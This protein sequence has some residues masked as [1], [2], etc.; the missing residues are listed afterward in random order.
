MPQLIML[1]SLINCKYFSFSLY[2]LVNQ[3]YSD[4]AIKIKVTIAKYNLLNKT[5]ETYSE[6][7]E[8]TNANA[9]YNLLFLIP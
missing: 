9:R 4:H 8:E 5:S 6:K 2:A 7:A 3:I 1:L